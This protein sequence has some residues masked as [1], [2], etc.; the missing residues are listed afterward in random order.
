MSNFDKAIKGRV[1]NWAG[2]DYQEYYLES[3]SD[4]AVVRERGDVL[5]E[6]WR[7]DVEGGG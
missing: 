2:L 4:I 5:D 6:M 1:V 7:A 3:V